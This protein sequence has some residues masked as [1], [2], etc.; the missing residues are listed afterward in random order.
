LAGSVSADTLVVNG[1]DVLKLENQILSLL[2]KQGATT[3]DIR[4]AVDGAKAD[5]VLK[6]QL[7]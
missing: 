5:K 7:R 2:A 6:L 3:A 4:A 1:Y